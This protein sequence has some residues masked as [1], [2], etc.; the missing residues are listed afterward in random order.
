MKDLMI[1]NLLVCKMILTQQELDKSTLEQFLSESEFC[2]EEDDKCAILV[3]W[4]KFKTTDEW[5]NIY[6]IKGKNLYDLWIKK[7]IDVDDCGN[8]L[9]YLKILCQNLLNKM[10]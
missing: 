7:E 9:A 4:F 3:K 8:A 10:Y 1:Y 2:W 6:L 5:P